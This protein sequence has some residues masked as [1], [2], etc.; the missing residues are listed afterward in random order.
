MAGEVRTLTARQAIDVVL[1]IALVLLLA[2]ACVTLLAPF[3]GLILWSLVFAI[4]FA[5]LRAR[6]MRY[7]LSSGR[8]ALVLGLGLSLLILVPLGIAATNAASMVPDLVAV[9]KGNGIHVPAPAPAV[10]DWPIVGERVFALWSEAA[11]NMPAFLK[12]VGPQL[13]KA[14]AWAAGQAGSL[15]VTLIGL[16]AALVIAA[17]LLAGWERNTR[18][19]EKLLGRL[20]GDPA[21][22]VEL[23]K[24]ISQ[25]VRSV[26]LGVVGVAFIQAL[27][28]GSAFFVYGMPGAGVLSLIVFFF[29]IVQVP[30]LI[31]TLPALLWAWTTLDTAAAG[32]M[33]VWLLIGGVS[34]GFL[35][36]LLLGRG[37]EVPMPVILLG[38]IGGMLVYGLVGLFVGP[39]LLAV[40][41]VLLLEWVERPATVPAS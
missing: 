25:T 34:D 2:G 11:S 39:V 21:R 32:I 19:G 27:L 12:D 15:A 23:S 36:P 29:G 6:L 7:G 10:R 24:L 4:C 33:T 18:A 3:S 41:Y 31:V 8:A 30:V 37:L 9:A 40:G 5:P 28:V 22:G 38:V 35:K 14:A 1:P 20:T 26:A 17:I 13:R 16:V